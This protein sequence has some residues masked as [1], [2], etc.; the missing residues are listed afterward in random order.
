LGFA[1]CKALDGIRLAFENFFIPV[2]EIFLVLYGLDQLG[3]RQ[4]EFRHLRDRRFIS[5]HDRRSEFFPERRANQRI[6]RRSSFTIS[7]G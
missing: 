6:Q 2:R 7:C 4:R 3:H 5:R 1:G